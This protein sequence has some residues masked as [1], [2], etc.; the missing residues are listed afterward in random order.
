REYVNGERISLL[1]EEQILRFVNVGGSSGRLLIP[2]TSGAAP[3]PAELVVEVPFGATREV[4]K[5]T[6]ER[7]LRREAKRLFAAEVAVWEPRLGVSVA[8]L[9]IKRM[10]TRWGTCNPTAR[11]VWLNLALIQ[12]PPRCLE[13]VVVHELAHLLVADHSRAFWALVERHLPDYRAAKALLARTPLWLD[14]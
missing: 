9:G 10:K 8:Q 12:R 2:V 3:S 6:L 4:R 1:G 14:D 13:Y 5:Q 11:R 7:H